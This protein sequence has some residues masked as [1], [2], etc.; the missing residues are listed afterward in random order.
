MLLSRDICEEMHPMFKTP[1]SEDT[2][3]P[4]GNADLRFCANAR[5]AGY[6]IHVHWDYP[7]QHFYGEVDLLGLLMAHTT[8]LRETKTAA[9]EQA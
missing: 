2:G 9:L 3:A 7:C 4:E 6:K 8:A 1:I 5:Q